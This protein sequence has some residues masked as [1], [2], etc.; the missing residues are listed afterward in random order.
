MVGALPPDAELQ[1]LMEGKLGA[2]DSNPIPVIVNDQDQSAEAAADDSC[3][4][5]IAVMLGIL[6]AAVVGLVNTICCRSG[7]QLQRP[8]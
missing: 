5:M 1:R 8:R 2:F 4:A 6:A 7:R 3:S